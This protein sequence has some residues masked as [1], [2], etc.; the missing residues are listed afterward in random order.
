[1]KA[2]VEV[3]QYPADYAMTRHSHAQ[4]SISFVL[5]GS[6]SER[7]SGL[8]QVAQ[9]GSIGMKAIDVQHENLVG[10]A[11]ALVLCL[12]PVCSYFDVIPQE[13]HWAH[14]L[15]SSKLVFGI[16]AEF[17]TG[18]VFGIAEEQ[19]RA[20]VAVFAPRPHTHRISPKWTA[21][22]RDW[23][24]ANPYVRPSI[25]DF[26]EERG[27]HPVYLSRAFKLVYGRSIGAYARRVRALAAATRVSASSD[28]LA[29]LAYE[30]GFADQSHLNRLFR[31]EFGT[32]PARYRALVNEAQSRA[33]HAVP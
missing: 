7:V 1:V 18:D 14:G 8:E 24:Q 17:L 32:S 5:S 33:V 9:A 15:S 23:I 31:I 21:E 29:D 20:F 22:L 12:R 6:I 4:S 11:G 28:R 25:S 30:L 16:A 13:W 26:A 3:H 27:L 10:P 2:G 19:L